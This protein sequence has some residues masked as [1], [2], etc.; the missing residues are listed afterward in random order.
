MTNVP[1]LPLTII[2]PVFGRPE[3]LARALSSIAAQPDPPVEVIVVDDCSAPPVS[4]DPE[5]I[6]RLTVRIIRQPENRGPAAARNAGIMAAQT[7]W[8]SFLDSDDW[9][10][11]DTLGTR[12]RMVTEDQASRPDPLAVYA[13]GWIDVDQDGRPLVSRMPRQGTNSRDFAS[14][15]WFSPGSCVIMNAKAIRE[16]DVLQDEALRRFE[17]FDWFLALGL[18][19]FR[20]A[21]QDI[22]AV[23][24]ERART[25]T[26]A[27]VEA[28]AGTIRRKWRALIAD[29]AMLRRLSAYLDVE[30][31][32]AHH[33][34]GNRIRAAFFL[35]RS[36]A[37]VPRLSLQ[38]SP[39]W[40]IE[41]V[42]ANAL[43]DIG[44]R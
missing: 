17:D 11:A 32:A 26:P 25:Q 3:R 38:L 43:V 41:R 40:T 30:C 33:F 13:C 16:A 39:G 27:K 2:M 12:W 22:V 14:G 31:A 36:L 28:V 5:T 8:I 35:A 44:G 34:A 42:A 6:G 23:A 29:R 20:L 10:L 1:L 19:G 4:I 18:K 24:I 21:I 9:L 15:C 37:R 7:E